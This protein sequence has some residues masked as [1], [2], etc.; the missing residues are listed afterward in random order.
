LKN[1]QWGILVS[2]EGLLTGNDGFLDVHAT[3]LAIQFLKDRGNA[4]TKVDGAEAED[5][6][7]SAIPGQDFGKSRTR[8]SVI[9]GQ[10]FR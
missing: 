3:E 2:K 10:R 9:L 1:F 7:V 5:V 8:I 6:R 4:V